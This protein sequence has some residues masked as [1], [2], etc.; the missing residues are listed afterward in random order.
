MKQIFITLIAA[1][2]A[3]AATSQQL[4][5]FNSDTFDGWHYN[6]PGVALTSNNISEGRVVL[7]VN[8]A[9]KALMLTSPEFSCQNID[10]I[11]AHVQWYTGTFYN[12]NFDLSLA[13]LTMVIDN[14][15]GQALDSVTVVPTVTGSSR[16]LHLRLAV[17]PGLE[18]CRLRFVSWTGTLISSGAIKRADISGVKA[19][20]HGDI[21]VGDVDND[22]VITIGDVTGLIDYLLQGASSGAYLDASDVDGDGTITIADVTA[23][24]DIILYGHQNP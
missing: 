22:G 16:T 8:S 9:K 5:Q 20:P 21:L 24:I 10:S 12:S 13:A 2:L 1:L 19:A 7:Y 18:S 4:P 14:S 17:P 15:T 11:A 3:T 23:L 6:N